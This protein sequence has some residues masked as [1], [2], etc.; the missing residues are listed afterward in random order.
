[1][2]TANKAAVIQNNN[3]VDLKRNENA[4]ADVASLSFPTLKYLSLLKF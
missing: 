1:M 3:A 4:V 2:T